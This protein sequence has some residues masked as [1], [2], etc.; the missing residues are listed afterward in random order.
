MRIGYIAKNQNISS[1]K[2]GNPIDEIRSFINAIL[3]DREPEVTGLDGLKNLFYG[4]A[5]KKSLETGMPV[6][7]GRV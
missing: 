1:L 7:V 3:E 4:L 6:R 5:A 2:D